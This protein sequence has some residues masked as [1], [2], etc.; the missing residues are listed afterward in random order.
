MNSVAKYGLICGAG[1]AVSALV[2]ASCF[3]Y[4][5]YM[6]MVKKDSESEDEIGPSAPPFEEETDPGYNPDIDE[7]PEYH[8]VEDVS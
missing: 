3:L 8:K 1:L 5:N 4:K 6:H 2:T 7:H